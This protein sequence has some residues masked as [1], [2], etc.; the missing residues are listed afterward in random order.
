MVL[1]YLWKFNRERQICLTLIVITIFASLFYAIDFGAFS[2]THEKDNA[3]AGDFTGIPKVLSYYISHEVSDCDCHSS[4]YDCVDYEIEYGKTMYTRETVDV[5]AF[6]TKTNIIAGD[7]EIRVVNNRNYEAFLYGIPYGYS[8]LPHKSN[9]EHNFVVMDS[10]A[11][12]HFILKCKSID[13]CIVDFGISTECSGQN[14]PYQCKKN[15]CGWCESIHVTESDSEHNLKLLGDT[16]VPGSDKEAE[17]DIQCEAYDGVYRERVSLYLIGG[18]LIGVL[19]TFCFVGIWITIRNFFFDRNHANEDE[20]NN[21]S[22]NS[23][24]RESHHSSNDDDIND[25]DSIEV[26]SVEYS[27]G[28]HEDEVHNNRYSSTP[29]GQRLVLRKDEIDDI[30]NGNVNLEITIHYD[31]SEEVY[32]INGNNINNSTPNSNDDNSN[33]ESDPLPTVA[34]L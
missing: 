8:V 18:V 21:E 11:I 22:S 20:A 33:V 17:M 15:S 3:H 12:W 32:S 10:T 24:R 4:E 14:G 28:F 31:N 34:E 16:C 30:T 29:S 26:V 7:I 6:Q 13:G 19:L 25:L 27:D 23:H 1:Q 2:W 9:C 5:T